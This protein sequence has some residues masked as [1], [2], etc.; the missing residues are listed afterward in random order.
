MFWRMYTEVDAANLDDFDVQP[1]ADIYVEIVDR[2]QTDI[3]RLHTPVVFAAQS[4]CVGLYT[5]SS[6]Q[7]IGRH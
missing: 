5:S 4:Q 6:Y 2:Q 1:S 7:R 3:F